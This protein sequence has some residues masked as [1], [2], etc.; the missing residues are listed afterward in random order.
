MAAAG[1]TAFTESLQAN[2]PKGPFFIDTGGCECALQERLSTEAWRCLADIPENVYEGQDGKWFY[3]VNPNDTDSLTE[4]ANSDSNPPDVAQAY[5]IKDDEW[6]S[7]PDDEEDGVTGSVPDGTCTG[8]NQTTASAK[9][10]NQ[11]AAILSGEDYPCWQPATAPLVIQTPSEWN[12]TGCKLG[13]FC[14]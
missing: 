10:Y 9:F 1:S 12:T 13:F 3:P 8:Y 2:K 4:P 11:S 7:F 6:W 5:E 14:E